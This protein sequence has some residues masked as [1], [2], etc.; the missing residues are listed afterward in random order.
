MRRI[1]ALVLCAGFAAAGL[2][3]VAARDL[4]D[5]R[6]IL[7]GDTLVY[8]TAT[9][10]ADGANEIV[11]EDIDRLR[12]ILRANP[13]IRVLELNSEGGSLYA[14]IEMAR[15]VLDFEL[16]TIVS[17][18]CFSSCVT[19]FLGG[20]KR[21]MMLGSKI[22]FHRNRWPPAAIETFFESLRESRGWQSPHD[23]ASWIYEDTQ[24]EVFDD[25]NYM[26]GRGVDP[27]F[28][29]RTKGVRSEDEWYPSR[30]ELVQ[31]GVLRE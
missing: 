8:D 31:A 9:A 21:R 25:L 19:V 10:V 23:M 15:I 14:G 4:I 26:I 12:T 29:I 16:D 1:R 3:P 7:R 11:T 28:A 2:S 6:F 20:A 13:G 18:E 17:G 30:L 24:S 22:G 5:A 27:V